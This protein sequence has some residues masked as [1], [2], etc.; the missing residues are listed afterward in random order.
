MAEPRPRRLCDATLRR[1]GGRR[2]RPLHLGARQALPRGDRGRRGPDVGLRPQRR[3]HTPPRPR[4][5]AAHRGRRPAPRPAHRGAAAGRRTPADQGHGRRRSAAHR[6]RTGGARPRTDRRLGPGRPRARGRAAAGHDHRPGE[7]HRGLRP[8]HP[9]AR[10]RDAP[11]GRRR[12]PGLPAGRQV[13]RGV[14]ARLPPAL[15]AGH[16]PGRAAGPQRDGRLRGTARL[17]AP[18]PS[19]FTRAEQQQDA[20]RALPGDHERH[21]DRQPTAGGRH[22]FRQSSRQRPARTPDTGQDRRPGARRA[23]T[24]LRLR[25]HPGRPHPAAGARGHHAAVARA[26]RHLRRRLAVRALPARLPQ[27]VRASG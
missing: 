16:R 18:A 8:A 26:A 10:G 3:H 20:P 24:G 15:G 2:R 25:E 12:P 27:A 13:V 21:G 9:T 7:Q 17:T 14:R 19:T 1:P 5:G 23:R 6:T 11:P 22:D 4:P